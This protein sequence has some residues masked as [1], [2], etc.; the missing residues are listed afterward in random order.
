[1]KVGVV[2]APN[3]EDGISGDAIVHEV[4]GNAVLLGGVDGLGHGPEA[5]IAAQAA[6]ESILENKTSNLAS[7]LRKC[8]E[9]LMG[10][11]GAAISLVLVDR[12]ESILTHAGIGNVTIYLIG[13]KRKHIRNSPGFVGGGFDKVKVGKQQYH[14][15]DTIIIHSDGISDKLDLSKYTDRVFGNVQL[16]AEAIARDYRNPMDDASILVAR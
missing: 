1:M 12:T 9:A 11:R 16:L 15:G 5:E 8:D 7:I 3:P 10:T 2:I 14:Q 4:I 13:E 6:V